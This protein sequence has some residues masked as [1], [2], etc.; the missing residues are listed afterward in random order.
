MQEMSAVELQ[1]H[2]AAIDADTNNPPLLLDVRQPWEFDICKLKGS[3]LIPMPQIPGAI[4]HLD[5]QRETIV[6]C[7]HGIRSRTV[8]RFL[9]QSG[10]DNVINLSGGVDEWAKTVD[11]SM[12]TY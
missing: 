3:Q 9:E 10:F 4:S 8:A 5:K 11:S 12:A 7:H 2:L 1:R 6:I